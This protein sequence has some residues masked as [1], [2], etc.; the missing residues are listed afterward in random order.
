M[1][2]LW[3]T[4]TIMIIIRD[5][6]SN[7]TCVLVCNVHVETENVINFEFYVTHTHLILFNLSLITYHNINMHLSVWLCEYIIYFWTGFWNGATKLSTTIGKCINYHFNCMFLSK[8]VKVELGHKCIW[9]ECLTFI[10]VKSHFR[11]FICS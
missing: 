7:S 9:V 8:F 1:N 6:L 10:K 11:I 2:P 4:S 5:I 3:P